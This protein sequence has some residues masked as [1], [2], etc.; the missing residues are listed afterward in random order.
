MSSDTSAQDAAMRM[1]LTPTKGRHF[2][3]NRTFPMAD[4]LR[5]MSEIARTRFSLRTK[6]DN[7]VCNVLCNLAEKRNRNRM[8]MARWKNAAT[9]SLRDP[10]R[11][12]E[13]K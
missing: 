9:P 4:Q 6:E 12:T 2:C 7:R 8:R 3:F 5:R 11:R 10:L 1:A 13:K